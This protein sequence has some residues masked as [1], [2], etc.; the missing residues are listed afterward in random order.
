MR[1]QGR[2]KKG[3]ASLPAPMSGPTG[4]RQEHLD[5]IASFAG[6]EQRRRLFRG[7]DVLTIKRTIGDL[8]EECRLFLNT[9]LMFMKKEKDPTTKLFDDDKWI[10]SL[11]EAQKITADV[12]EDSVTYDQQAVDPKRSGPSKWE[13]S[14][15]STSHDDSLRSAKEKLQPCCSSELGLKAATRP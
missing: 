11:T 8:P 9:Q 15:G 3:I 13:K 1:E 2:S 7:L 12:P 10:R 14:C 5:A 6:A 4:E